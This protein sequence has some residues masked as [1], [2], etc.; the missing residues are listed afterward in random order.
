MKKDVAESVRVMLNTLQE[1][2]ATISDDKVLSLFEE[3]EKYANDV[4]NKKLFEVQ[5]AFG[6][7]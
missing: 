7:R 2:L 3:G 5:E 4:A 6:L 1:Q